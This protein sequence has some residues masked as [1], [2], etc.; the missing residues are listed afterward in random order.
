MGII[1]VD[2]PR[3][4]CISPT[5]SPCYTFHTMAPEVISN[6]WSSLQWKLLQMPSCE[7]KKGMCLLLIGC[8]GP[9]RGRNHSGNF[10]TMR[11]GTVSAFCYKRGADI[12]SV[13]RFSFVT[14]LLALFTADSLTNGRSK[15]ISCMELPCLALI[16]YSAQA[17]AIIMWSLME[18]WST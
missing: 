9:Q 8:R 10:R 13:M 2:Q 18:A 6:P 16:W 14:V 5:C 4:N 12:I 1:V 7:Q 3:D 17:Q 15:G 11:K